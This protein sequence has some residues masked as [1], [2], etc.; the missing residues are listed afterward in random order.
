MFVGFVFVCTFLLLSGSRAENDIYDIGIGIAD[1][2]GPAAD[3]NM[4][5]YAKVSQVTR[6]IHT[7]QYSRAFVVS[8]N[9]SRVALVSIDSGM[10]SHIVK[11]EVVKALKEKFGE[12]YTE[13]NV[14]I[15]ATH[16]HATPGGHLQ[17]LLY[18]IPSQG[19]I[20]Q[21]FF[22]L[23]KGIV[24]TLPLVISFC[25]RSC[26]NGTVSETGERETKRMLKILSSEH[27]LG[28]F[29]KLRRDGTSILLQIGS[30]VKGIR[31]NYLRKRNY[32]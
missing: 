22:S 10:V 30:I 26:G 31:T 17:Y 18:L 4:M 8:D 27:F 29:E 9:S 7:R 21:T 28:C 19:F 20:R 2:T 15:T 16:T 24:K 1:I 6:G 23:V 11:M 13:E 25:S 5:G 32:I 12:L 3:I 14:M